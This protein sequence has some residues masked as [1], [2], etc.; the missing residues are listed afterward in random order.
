MLAGLATTLFT[1]I[2]ISFFLNCLCGS[3]KKTRTQSYV[4]ELFEYALTLPLFWVHLPFQLLLIVYQQFAVQAA[5]VLSA[6]VAFIMIVAG[7]REGHAIYLG[8]AL[9]LFC[10]FA[11]LVYWARQAHNVPKFHAFPLRPSAVYILGMLLLFLIAAPA[12]HF[13]KA[14]DKTGMT[15]LMLLAGWTGM[16]ALYGLHLDEKITLEEAQEQE[17][18]R[19]QEADTQKKQEKTGWERLKFWQ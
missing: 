4:E 15:M 14:E 16:G 8:V 9:T 17:R 12:E 6:L 10:L 2:G 5:A 7:L 18:L 11:G 19:A 1:F 3:S 13:S